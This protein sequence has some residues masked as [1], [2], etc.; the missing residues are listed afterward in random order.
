LNP[1]PPLHPV[2]DAL[3]RATADLHAEVDASVPLGQ[4]KPTLADYRNHLRLLLDWTEALRRL[5]VETHRLDVQQ[6]ALQRDLLECDHLLNSLP[7]APAAVPAVPA[8]GPADSSP[9]YGWGV[10]YVIEG[11]QLGGQVLY[12]RLAEPLAPHSLAFLKGAGPGTGARWTA[13]LSTLEQQIS[14]PAEIESACAG[15]VDAFGLLLQLQRAK[16]SE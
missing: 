11:S 6:A 12:R 3:R 4:P 9:A 7:A 8:S 2:R 16:A 15:A 1:P 10:A 14:T 5:P 13:F